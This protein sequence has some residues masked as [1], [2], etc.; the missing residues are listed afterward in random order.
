[1]SNSK[2][3]V[4]L[5]VGNI[6]AF[7]ATLAVNGLASTSILGGKTTAEISDQYSTLITPAGYVFAI[8]G[9]IYALLAAFVVYQVLPSKRN[10][11]FQKQ[12]SALFIISSLF[13]IGWIFLWQYG[14]IALSV[15]PIAAL[16]VTLAAIY[17]RLKIGKSNAP[18]R[19]KACVQLPFSVYFAWITVATAADV[20]AAASYA[21]WLKWT[22]GDAV[23]GILAAVVL[24]V[25][26]LV[27]IASRRD[28]AFSLVVIWALAGIAVK[29][30]ATPEIVY[31]AVLGAVILAAAALVAVLRPKLKT[32]KTP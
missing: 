16:W 31:T 17:L 24:L 2:T 18:L 7:V 29:Q 22:S 27:V 32:R 25:I 26:T 3:T 13:N 4:D 10:N 21:G 12:I 30:S 28:V 19:E 15:A 8:W 5:Q 6:L 9:I 23:W 1:M 11:P 14:H 20:A